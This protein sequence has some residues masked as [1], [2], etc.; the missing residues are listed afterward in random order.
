MKAPLLLLASAALLATA[1]LSA[2]DD[3][4]ADA[5]ALVARYEAGGVTTSEELAAVAEA[6]VHL[7]RE[8]PRRFHEALRVFDQAIA[9]D[10]E[11]LDVRVALGDLFLAKYNGRDAR[12][13]YEQVL[14]RDPGHPRA[15]LGLARVRRFDGA[16]DVTDLVTQALAEDPDLV[17]A[18]LLLARQHLDL[19]DY[20]AADREAERAL[21]ADPRSAEAHALL[22][23][24]ALLS[25]DEEELRRRLARLTE[26]APG[27][28][29]PYVVLAEVAARSR[30][31]RRAVELAG[32]AVELDRKSWRGWAL[33]GV[34]RLRTG[35]IARGRRDLE[36][37]FAGDPFDVWTKNTLDLLDAMADDRV[38]ESGRFELVMPAA[39]AD[40][41]ALYLAPL[42]EEAYDRLAARYG[43]ALPTPI[44]LEVFPRHADFSVRTVGLVGL[45]AL[46]VSF[47]PVIAMDAPTATSTG[48]PPSGT[49]SPT[50][51]TCISPPT[52]CRA[53]S[54]RGWRSTRSAGRVRAGVTG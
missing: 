2:G 3:P 52:G 8:E 16:T 12:E 30:L 15:L 24:S 29:E 11:N 53:G 31:Y 22:A 51:S 42:A 5:R 39:E 28:P 43:A 41:L 27:D 34:N 26:V 45:G 18:R 49:S 33:A 50:P 40:L 10:P 46:G 6:L 17:P 13:T 44:R 32:R 14:A 38:V 1:P 47:G 19:E 25:G 48:A 9:A 7:G 21:R 37:A 54:P 23:A 20:A 35:E 4:T 36:T